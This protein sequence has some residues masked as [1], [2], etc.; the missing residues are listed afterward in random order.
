M[1]HD[2]NK[3]LLLLVVISGFIAFFLPPL[4]VKAAPF[5]VGVGDAQVFSFKWAL[6][7]VACGALGWYGERI[8]DYFGIWKERNHG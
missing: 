1:L 5:V 3:R 6:T 8:F 2:R 7:L 4:A